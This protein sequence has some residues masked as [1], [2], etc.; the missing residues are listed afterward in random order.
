M[1]LYDFYEIPLK[2]TSADHHSPLYNTYNTD[3]QTQEAAILF[4]ISRGFPKEKL[5]LGLNSYARSYL[6]FKN[7]PL[8]SNKK[9]IIGRNVNRQGSIGDFTKTTG[10]LALYEVDQMRFYFYL[11]I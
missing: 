4:Y 7:N 10:V 6:L 5:L 2:L 1:F 9:G 8:N 3:V 11:F